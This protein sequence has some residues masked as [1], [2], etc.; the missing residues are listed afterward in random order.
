MKK[1]TIAILIL[2]IGFASIAEAKPFYI[3]LRIGFKA[4]LNITLGE[5]EDGNAV[6]LSLSQN[7]DHGTFLGYDAETDKFS[8]KILKS[9]PAVKNGFVNPLIIKEDSPVDPKLIQQFTNFKNNQRIVYIKAGE[10]KVYE[11]GECLI[12][13]LFYFVK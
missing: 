3:H 11:E 2:I 10:Y 6:C 12:A 13:E 8:V 4:K 9:D 7:N 1:I 5:C